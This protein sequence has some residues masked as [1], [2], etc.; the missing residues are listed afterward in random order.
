MAETFHH[1]ARVL[2]QD[3]VY[4]PIE[5]T[6]TSTIGLIYTAPDADAVKFPV[7]KPVLFL[8]DRYQAAE[9]GSAGTGKDSIDA[10]Y[11]HIGVPIIGIRVEEKETIEEQLASIVGDYATRTGVHAFYKAKNSVF[12]VPKILI[13]PGFT[14]QRVTNG[15]TQITLA[16]GGT[17]YTAANT[18]VVINANGYGGGAKAIP[19]IQSGVI[20]G[21]QI[22]NCGL[23]YDEEHLTITIQ[24]DGENAAVDDFQLGT[25]A[26]PVVAELGGIANRLRSTIIADAPNGTA[27]QSIAA[28]RDFATERIFM[29]DNYPLVQKGVNITAEPPSARVAGLL[30]KVDN[31]EGFWVSP[32]NHV[33]QGVLGTSK[34]IDDSGVGGESDYLN[35]NDV[36]TVVHRGPGFKLWGNHGCSNDPL[37][38]FF[39]VGRTRDAIFDSIETSIDEYAPGKPLNLAFF[40]GVADSVN[41]KLRYWTSIGALI[42]G[43]V[44]VDPAL[45][46]PGQLVLGKP[47]FSMNF[48]PV[49]V[50]EDIQI[51]ASREP[52]YYA[53]LVNQVVLALAQ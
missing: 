30:A 10:I 21:I 25:A 51:L 5:T 31:E 40:E 3:S 26:N 47:K 18:R 46:P 34:P 33:L 44:W 50:A 11:D 14:S 41:E 20:T 12:K 37:W 7:N 1:G 35:E 36:A 9:L 22:V 15:I 2:L 42:G 13:A 16:S 6:D 39:A 48:E 43:K 53:E 19:V 23:G 8:A 38:Q 27:E 24:G 4:R 52:G 17:G 49:G 45:N 29:V 28:R 32:S